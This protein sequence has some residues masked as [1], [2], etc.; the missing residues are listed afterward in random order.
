MTCQISG[1]AKSPVGL[2]R[3]VRNTFT[4]VVL[5]IF[6]K[7]DPAGKLL[8]RSARSCLASKEIAK[9]ARFLSFIISQ[10]RTLYL[11]FL[12][13]KTPHNKEPDAA[14]AP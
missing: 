3:I 2:F 14:L 11:L 7:K 13:R 9:L 12:L 4:K 10:R 6:T 5:L 8:I 1:T